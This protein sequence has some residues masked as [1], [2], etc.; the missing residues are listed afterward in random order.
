M[1]GTASPFTVVMQSPPWA[2]I[3]REV[4]PA[5]FQW[6]DDQMLYSTTIPDLLDAIELLLN[7]CI[8]LNLRLQ[9][10]KCLLNASVVFGAAGRLVL[11]TG[12]ST[13]LESLRFVRWRYPV[14]EHNSNNLILPSTG[15]EQTYQTSPLS[16]W[17]S[18]ILWNACTP[19]PIRARNVR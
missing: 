11:M 1:P 15:C 10:G 2:K 17:R 3:P 5:L 8:R 14:P 12:V 18:R 16:L 19:R 7:L 13:Q 6:F 9:H 4:A